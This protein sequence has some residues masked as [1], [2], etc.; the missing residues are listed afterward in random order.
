MASTA[1]RNDNDLALI[2]RIAAGNRSAL[3]SLYDRHVGSLLALA[4][5]M[6]G[7]GNEAEEVVQELFLTVWR[8]AGHYRPK[9]G[10]VRAWLVHQTRLQALA[11]L[12]EVPEIVAQLHP[13]RFA[14]QPGAAGLGPAATSP[15]RQR[16]R[17]ALLRLP[18]E[19]RS[20]LESV[21]FAAASAEE[22]CQRTGMSP[23]TLQQRLF[24]TFDAWRRS[25]A[26]RTA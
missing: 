24:A 9:N 25:A 19:E 11:M 6:V 17:R 14:P 18:P 16:A 26:G 20:V 21:Y 10:T 1:A 7:P 23:R 8:D 4:Q 13:H 5:Q 15:A 2:L 3:C 12:Q 22:I